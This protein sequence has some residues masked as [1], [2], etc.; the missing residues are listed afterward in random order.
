M[1][2]TPLNNEQLQRLIDQEPDLL[3]L[4]VRSPQEYFGLG[5]IP[6]STL[7]PMQEIPQ[8]MAALNPDQ[9]TVVIC[10]HG[11]RSLNASHFL[12]HHG[13]TAIYNLTAG[14]AEWN[15]ARSYTSEEPA[16]T[17]E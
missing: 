15:G 1:S 14:M 11:V 9:K 6:G 16:Q 12:A 13:F 17:A 2:V 3:L 8:Q 5:H 10:E 4:D 7:L